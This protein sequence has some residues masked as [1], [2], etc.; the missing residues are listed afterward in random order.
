MFGAPL[1]RDRVHAG[2]LLAETLR[3]ETDIDNPLV[4]ALPRGG[5]PVAF[6]IARQLHGDLDIFLVRKIGAPGQEE[7][8]IGA[9][10]SGGVR[11]L[12]E[13]LIEHLKI[14]PAVIELLTARERQEIGR[15]ESLYREGR[16]ALEIANRSVVLVDD[17]L[18]TG[19]TMLAA[20]RAV[21]QRQPRRILVAAPVASAATC[22]E[23]RQYVDRI[24]CLRTPEP[25][26]SVGAW[27]EDFGQTTDAEVGE[28]LERALREKVNG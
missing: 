16:R 21:R 20:V 7:L 9:I 5:V 24:V 22:R 26:H 27:Y 8:A 17:G 6:E 28:L 4:L 14:S 25:F 10:A 11:V 3:S 23:F 2:E 15:R 19:A 12:N 13:A 1:F 18:A